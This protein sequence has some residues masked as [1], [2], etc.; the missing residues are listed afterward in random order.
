[1]QIQTVRL[2]HSK[3]SNM[4]ALLRNLEERRVGYQFVVH[5]GIEHR[6]LSRLAA[7]EV[8]DRGIR[9]GLSKLEADASNLFVCGYHR[10]TI[11][12]LADV[13]GLII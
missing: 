12:I 13:E 10:I 3:F 2:S 4:L 8:H 6:A 1:M 5:E 11:A 7:V 9:L